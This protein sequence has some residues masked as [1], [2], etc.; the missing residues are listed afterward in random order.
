MAFYHACRSRQKGEQSIAQFWT[1][2]RHRG[3]NGGDAEPTH[4]LVVPARCDPALRLPRL[5]LLQPQRGTALP[6]TF[7][8]DY[9]VKAAQRDI[10]GMVGSGAMNRMMI[11]SQPA[12]RDSFAHPER[13]QGRRHPRVHPPAG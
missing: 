2:N 13:R 10:I 4:L 7:D 3:G 1:S 11:L 9:Q 12:L 5:A 8:E 6:N